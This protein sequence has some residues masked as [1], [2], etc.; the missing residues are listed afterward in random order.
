M[1]NHSLLVTKDKTRVNNCLPN[2]LSNSPNK[3][4]ITDIY[5]LPPESIS[6][7]STIVDRIREGDCYI[8][9]VVIKERRNKKYLLIKRDMKKKE[10]KNINMEDVNISAPTI[11]R[12]LI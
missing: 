1:S 12:L 2:L 7:A 3:L 11:R 9:E 10:N 5:L 6:N 8:K 4:S